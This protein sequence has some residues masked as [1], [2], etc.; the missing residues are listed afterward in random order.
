MGIVGA[1]SLYVG[2]GASAGGLTALQVFFDK[3]AVDSGAAFIVVQ[4]LSPDFDS[5][6]DELLA[7]HTSMSIE[8][9]AH[10]TDVIADSIYL[11]PPKTNIT[12][13]NGCLYLSEQVRDGSLN[14]PIDYFFR[15]LAD[16]AG[17]RSVGIIFSGTGSDGSRGIKRIKEAGGLV[18]IQD[19]ESAEFDG[20]PHVAAQTGTA[21]LILP[22][23]SLAEHLSTFLNS[24]MVRT[25][26][27]FA[28]PRVRPDDPELK[29]VFELLSVRCGIDFSH[30]NP[31]SLLLRVSRRMDL[32][33]CRLLP[34]YLQILKRSESEQNLLAHEFLVPISAFFRN[35]TLWDYLSTHILEPLIKSADARQGLRLWVPGCATGEEAF[36]LAIVVD[37]CMRRCQRSVPIKIFATDI[38][39]ST[40]KQAITGSFGEEIAHD[41]SMERLSR[42]FVHNGGHYTVRPELR[43]SV[44]FA[45]HDLLVD[46]PYPGTDLIL[47]RKVV[48]YFHARAAMSVLSAFHFSLNNSA[49]LVL[50]ESDSVP[51]LKSFYKPVNLT[52]QHYT[53]IPNSNFRKPKQDNASKPVFVPRSAT[54]SPLS[55]PSALQQTS[56]RFQ[57]VKDTLIDRYIPACFILNVEQQLVHAYGRSYSY[58]K[59]SKPDDASPDILDVIIDELAGPLRSALLR[60]KK[61][62]EPVQHSDILCTTADHSASVT[63]IVKHIQ[64]QGKQKDYFAVSLFDGIKNEPADQDQINIALNEHRSQRILQL[65]NDLADRQESVEHANEVLQSAG[66]ELQSTNEELMSSNEELQSVN[67]ELQSVNEELYSVNNEHQEKIEEL[68]S[69]RVDLEHVLNATAVCIVILDSDLN[70]RKFTESAKNYFRLINTDIGRPL[71]DISHSLN[72]NTIGQDIRTTRRTHQ[73]QHFESTSI[74]GHAVQINIL[75]YQSR[76]TG[77]NSFS[78]VT[79]T[80]IPMISATDPAKQQQGISTPSTESN[81]THYI[82]AKPRVRVLVVDDNEV[83]RR[84]IKLQLQEIETINI[85]IFE[86]HSVDSAIESLISKDIGVVL[87]DYRLSHETAHDLARKISEF[88]EALPLILLSGFP[89]EE[90]QDSVPASLLDYYL[91]KDDLSPLLLELSIRHA[92][93]ASGN[94]LPLLVKPDSINED[95]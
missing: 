25:A 48:H 19:R 50:S 95:V 34:D 77:K 23:D 94:A 51:E 53:K 20:M 32:H 63:M 10:G 39:K 84:S 31:R 24:S 40:M 58:L 75:P 67:E 68:L 16:H 36:S 56:E 92:I 30:Y 76:S 65:E 86:A 42:Y 33:R 46:A 6:M 52:L 13:A 27:E 69:M 72:H 90:L 64:R 35:P 45:A 87:I 11:I 80:V 61:Q 59:P 82:A 12:L 85:E 3:M 74:D 21:D 15:S 28:L 71:S 5:H 89:R 66:S 83:D 26:S 2:I 91:N 70:I 22:P 79:L 55:R 47:C 7:R 4:H 54:V 43:A 1:P 9:V 78:A 8:V 81:K 44:I 88:N 18:L 57:H 93:R 60:A 41:V 37:E 14:L 49:S 73:S 62:T 38:D 29:K 17:H